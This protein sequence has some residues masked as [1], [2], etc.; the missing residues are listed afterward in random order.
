MN[1]RFRMIMLG[2]MSFVGSSAVIA[3]ADSIRFTGQ[4]SERLPVLTVYGPWTLRDSSQ[5]VLRRVRESSFVQWRATDAE[6]LLL[7]S[8]DGLGWRVSFSPECPGLKSAIAISFVAPMTDDNN[9][10]DSILLDNGTRCYSDRVSIL[11]V[12]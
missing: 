12:E 8:D 6:T 3:D 10:Y 1:K 4:E 5:M 11:A 9:H 7:F 2:I